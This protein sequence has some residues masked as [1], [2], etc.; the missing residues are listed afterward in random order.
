M[1]FTSYDFILATGLIL[2][3]YYCIP[4]RFQWVFLLVAGY[5]MYCCA[6]VSCLIFISITTFGTYVAAK[7]ISDFSKQK[8]N[9]LKQNKTTLDKAARITYKEQIKR[10]QKKWLVYALVVDIGLFVVLRYSFTDIRIPLGISFYTFQTLGY[11]FDVYNEKIT[12]EKNY[13]KLALFVG[14][15]PQLSVGPI[16]RYEELSKSLYSEH[17]FDTKTVSSGLQ[18]VLWG[19]FKKLVIA[20]R[21]GVALNALLAA[22]QEYRG[23]WFLVAMVAYALRLYADFTGG[24]DI[25]IGLAQAM[26]ITLRENFSRPFF[27]KSIKEYWNRWHITLGTWF[28]DYMFYPVSTSKFMLKVSKN[29]RRMLG[30]ELGKRVPVY[31]ATLLVWG[32][33]GL[34]HGTTWNFVVWG[35]VNG[36]IL[37]VSRELAPVYNKFHQHVP[38]AEKRWY[39]AFCVIRTLMLMSTLRM[40]DCYTDVRVP[41]QLLFSVVTERNMAELWSGTLLKLGLSIADYCILIVG[42]CLMLGVSLWQRKCPVRESVRKL[43]YPVR[44]VLW[45]G[46]FVMVLLFGMYGQGYEESQFIYNQF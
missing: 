41:V 32:C 23:V 30:E 40:L 9:Y 38:V 46:L 14:F 11:L 33:T 12:A 25:A 44:V 16:S 18:R 8:E 27:A 31:A 29:A 6:G 15:F 37:L 45:L 2:V 34:W 10:K 17:R 7:R 36:V 24:I 13:A 1:N 42:I 28:R 35:L 22:P 5:G 26:G 4:K 39:Q 19:Y 20:D 21:V 43:P 3:I